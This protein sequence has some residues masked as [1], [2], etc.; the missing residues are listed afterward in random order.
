[1]KRL[2]NEFAHGIGYL[3]LFAG[4]V[5][6]IGAAGNSDLGMALDEVV[7]YML[8]GLVACFGGFFLTRWRI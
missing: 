4:F 1:M 5:L 6:C 2:A 8:A 7:R 3:F